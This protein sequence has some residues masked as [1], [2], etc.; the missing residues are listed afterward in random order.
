MV[1][2]MR[3]STA[4]MAVVGNEKGKVSLSVTQLRARVLLSLVST[5]H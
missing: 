4:A 3:G 5:A 1:L 2:K